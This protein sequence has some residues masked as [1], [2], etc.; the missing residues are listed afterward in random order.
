MKTPS[1]LQIILFKINEP[2][3]NFQLD[4]LVLSVGGS[5]AAC[6]WWLEAV[7]CQK[8]F[9]GSVGSLGWAGYLPGGFNKSSL[10]L[11]CDYWVFRLVTVKM[12]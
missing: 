4:S 7:E 2:V 10:R 5:K 11:I 12:K 6:P 8:Q 9:P 3:G 1:K